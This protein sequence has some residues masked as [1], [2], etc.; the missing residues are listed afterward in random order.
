MAADVVPPSLSTGS[1]A[2]GRVEPDPD[3]LAELAAP[4]DRQEWWRARVERCSAV[5]DHADS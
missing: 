2:V 3:L 1:L 5:L 4:P